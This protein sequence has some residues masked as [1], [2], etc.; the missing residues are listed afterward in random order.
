MSKNTSLRKT[1][2]SRKAKHHLSKRF[3]FFSLKLTLVLLPLLLL[4]SIYL[5]SVVREKFEGHHWAV[6]AKVYARPFE[7]YQ[8]LALSPTDLIDAL[9]T[10]GYQ[11]AESPTQPGQYRQTGSSVDI[12]TRG[13]SFA[14]QKES[15]RTLQINFSDN[16][17]TAIIGTKKNKAI[18]LLRLEPL[19]IGSIFPGLHEDRHPIKLT[20][21]PP[22]MLAGLVAVEDRYFMEHHGFSIRGVIRAMWSNIHT[23]GMLQ[24]GSTITQQLVKNFYLNSE[25]TLTRKVIEVWMA[26]LL[27]LHY[28]KQS[29]LETY[30]NEVYLGQEGNRAIHGFGLASQYYFHQPLDELR[31]QQMALLIALVKG[32]SYYDPWRHPERATTHRNVVLDVMFDQGIISAR[33]RDWAQAQPLDVGNGAAS[34]VGIY[35]AFLDFVRRQLKND[36]KDQDLLSEGLQIFTTVDPQIQKLVEHSLQTGIAKLEKNYKSLAD[37]KLQGAAVVTN[38]ANGEVLAMTGDRNPQYPG[39]NR[40]LDAR[41]PVGS[42]LKPFV[43]LTALENG[44]YSLASQIDDSALKWRT[45]NGTYWKPQNYDRKQHGQ[46]AIIDVLAHSYNLATARIGLQIGVKKLI[47]VLRRAGVDAPLDEVPS[48]LLGAGGLSPMEVAALYQVI[49]AE[50][51]VVP[52][53]AI[54]EVYTAKGVPLKRYGLEME[55]R[56]DAAYIEEISFAMETVFS[57]GTARAAYDKFPFALRLAGKTGTTDEQRDSWF[58]GFSSNYNTVVWLGRDDNSKLPLTGATG[59]LPIWANIM[60]ALPNQS[61]TQPTNN[62]IDWQWIDKTSGKRTDEGCGGSRRLPID[63]RGPQADYVPCAGRGWLNRPTGTKSP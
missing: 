53:R 61:L 22:V 15:S 51:F 3:L 6:P 57:T 32:P 30:L 63:K 54:R 46:V 4:A 7:I 59:A 25:R 44:R 12:T 45:A 5:D 10:L 38:P 16:T 9:R 52:L 48:L 8:G 62:N 28:S 27:E 2:K 18:S 40:A 60:A 41:R 42:L 50:G 31:L 21:M 47:D 37:G 13:F 39:F 19:L 49:P 43:F 35:P 56:F 17:V 36:Y 20:E 1:R 23:G 24:G 14:D 11:M 29:I 33:E 58:A 55:Q 34:R 26:L